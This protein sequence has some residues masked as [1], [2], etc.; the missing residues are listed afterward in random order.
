MPAH[1]WIDT[2]ESLGALVDEVS[3]AETYA[4]DTEFHRERSYFPHLALVQLAW[5]GGEAVIDP[6]AVDVRPLRQV[7]EGPGLAICHAADQDLEVMQYACG[8]VPGRLFDTQVAAAF[9]GLGFASLSRL[10][11]ALVGK[12]LPKGDRLTDW[13][14]RPL[15]ASQIAYAAADVEY[16]HHIR[17]ALCARAAASGTLA[18]VE[19]ECERLRVKPHGPPDPE[20]AWWRIKGSRSLRGKSRGVAQE[21]AAWRER[22]A[23]ERDVP[24]R[25]VLP[26]LALASIVQRPPTSLDQLR[27]GRGLDPRA[28]KGGTAAAILA[29]VE[30][31][32]ALPEEKLRRP[33]PGEPPADE[34]VG[35]SVALG[36]ALVAQIAAEL[37]IEPSLLGTRAD[38]LART[39]GRDSGRLASGWR[40]E[41][42]GNR[43]GEILAGK[44]ALTGDGSGGVRIVALP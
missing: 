23:A 32:L 24:P 7:L 11:Q 41:L 42:L 4:F 8:T 20:T 2:D 34:D 12:T 37:K 13:T 39:V 36:L 43:L 18:W 17:D 30:A 3:A 15:D 5:P 19:E 16:L 21:V 38:V 22:T 25:F 1:R 10:V 35:P 26:D 9:T 33:P 40:A 14:R 31:G 6:L 27:E 44:A 29:S 28:I